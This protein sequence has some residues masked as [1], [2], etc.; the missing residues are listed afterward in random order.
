MSIPCHSQD[1]DGYL[2][3]VNTGAS[4]SIL[5]WSS[6][7]IQVNNIGDHYFQRHTCH[8]GG[9]Q[10][11]LPNC[12][13]VDAL[14]RKHCTF[15]KSREHGRRI[16]NHPIN[17]NEKVRGVSTCLNSKARKG[18]LNF[19]QRQWVGSRIHSPLNI[20]EW[21][22]GICAALNTV[23]WKGGLHSDSPIN[24]GRGM[25]IHTPLNSSEK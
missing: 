10:S 16:I 18:D 2:S 14:N 20:G 21:G 6:L 11:T 12:I 22:M 13:G 4:L 1:S 23:G 8:Y 24:N 5:L 19:L 17:I 9:G 15:L 7:L 25:G 3:R